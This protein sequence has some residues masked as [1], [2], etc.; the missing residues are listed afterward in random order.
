M[1]DIDVLHDLNPIE[2]Q[3]TVFSESKNPIKISAPFEI[4]VKKVVLKTKSL[5]IS[6]FP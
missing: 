4:C 5:Q 2:L 1:T 6:K 3:I